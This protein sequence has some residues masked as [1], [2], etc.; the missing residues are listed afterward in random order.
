M[1]TPRIKVKLVER[2][3]YID[4]DFNENS[5]GSSTYYIDL[6]KWD[7]FVMDNSFVAG[8]V[9]DTIKLIL[10]GYC[11]EQVSRKYSFQDMEEAYTALFTEEPDSAFTQV[12]NCDYD[13]VYS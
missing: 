1:C 8:Y 4:G 2:P 3:V 6:S 13:V 9:E 7:Q 11:P 10:Q 5:R 12:I